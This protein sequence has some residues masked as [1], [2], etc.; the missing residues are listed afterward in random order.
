MFFNLFINDLLDEIAPVRVPGLEHGLKG[1]MFAD[2]TV[3]VAESRDDLICKLSS[4]RRWMEAMS[5][6]VNPSKCGVMIVSD[7]DIVC[8]PS[9]T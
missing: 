7:Q 9:G 6:E 8:A 3:I 2:D 4:I 1:L 5:M